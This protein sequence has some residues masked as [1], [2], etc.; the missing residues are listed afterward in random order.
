MGRMYLLIKVHK[1]NFPG[2]AVVSQI[3]D[4][5]YKVCKILTDILNPIA[6]SGESYVENSYELKKFL[7]TMKIDKHDIQASFD[8]VALY[9][10]IPIEIALECV[11]KKLLNDD[12]LASRTDWNADDIIKL[13]RICLETHFKTIDGR[14]FTQI[15]G[16][17]IGKSISGPLADIYMIWFE[18]QY[19][20]NDNNEFRAF[21]KSWKRFRD[22]IYVIWSGGNEA[23]DCFF[24]QLNYKEPRIQFT[25]EREKNNTLAFLDISIKRLADR[26]ITNVYRKDTHTQK[27]I[28]WKSNCSKNC[29]LG[30][31]KGLIHR[32]H[33][34]CDQKE[35]LLS[36]LNL[37]KDVFIS[38]GYPKKLV[39]KTIK[40]SWKVE[41]EK[42]LKALVLEQNEENPHAE[43][44]VEDSGYYD[45]LHI[46]YIAGFAEKLA[47]D[48]RVVNV[49]VT[50]QKGR[51]IFNSV[52]KLKPLKHPDEKKNL[53]YCLGCKSCDQHY[54]G[55]TQQ[56]FSSRK[57]QHEYAIRHKK[58][59]NGLAQ[60]L[61]INK[62]HSIDWG[63]RA[64]LDFE[65]HW[66][67]RKIKEA[68][69]IDCINPRSNISP[70]NLMNLEKGIEIANCWKEFNPHLK[71]IFSKKIPHRNPT[72]K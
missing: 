8:V 16:T 29:K 31:L 24:W 47:K 51:T 71:K 26:L 34:L 69:F 64:F 1:K 17:P 12:T 22:D 3:D 33:L 36:E 56:F 6:R 20:F 46:P 38:N 66:R 59:T 4:P 60:H 5:T 52:C 25:I 44:E 32:A 58:S 70:N 65:P 23:L 49:G 57:Y 50:F 14:I 2:R 28:N 72:E 39:E 48:L 37:L 61:M 11:R 10:S 54:I 30:I 13:L 18:E 15:D 7:S 41:L 55:E 21:I 19:I 45:T 43:Q 67:K 53:I 40:N 62:K 27:Y 63:R 42:Q 9:P 68:L 35:D